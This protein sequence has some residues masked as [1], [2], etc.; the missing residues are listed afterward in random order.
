MLL[1]RVAGIISRYNMWGPGARVAVAVSGGADSICL[2]HALIE[3]SNQW[4]LKLGI[5]HLNH[6]LRGAESDADERFVRDL[7]TGARLPFQTARREFCP[8]DGNLEEAAREAR[9]AFFHDLIASGAYD[10]IA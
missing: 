4:N 5:V 7:A 6:S 10:R 3:L 8:Q 9:L 2:L 1:D